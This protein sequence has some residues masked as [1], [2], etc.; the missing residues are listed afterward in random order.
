MLSDLRVADDPDLI[1][2]QTA[3]S[4]PPVTHRGRQKERLCRCYGRP[5]HWCRSP[6]KVLRSPPPGIAPRW[7]WGS[8]WPCRRAYTPPSSENQKPFLYHFSIKMYTSMVYSSALGKG[9]YVVPTL[10]HKLVITYHYN[11]LSHQKKS[12]ETHLQARQETL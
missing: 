9:D 3:P 7:W 11:N 8:R 2:C 1:E 12:L 4:F 5:W 6:Q 10:E